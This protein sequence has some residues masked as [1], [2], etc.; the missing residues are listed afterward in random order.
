[1]SKI[2][3]RMVEG[4]G[5]GVFATAVFNE[6]DI[7]ERCEILPLSPEDTIKVNETDLKYYTFKYDDTR[8]CLVLG[9]GEIFNH[10]DKPNVSYKLELFGHDNPRLFMVFR[11]IKRITPSEQMFIDYTAD[12]QVKAKEYTV[13]LM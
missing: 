4:M 3:I 5:R 1:M 8:D 2:I 10:D 12:T 7:I 9:S 6:G 11:A 13:N